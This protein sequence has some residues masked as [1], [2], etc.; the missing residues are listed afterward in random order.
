MWYLEVTTRKELGRKQM[1]ANKT[2]FCFVN[3]KNI[4]WVLKKQN[5]TKKSVEEY[6]SLRKNIASAFCQ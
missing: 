4:P 6:Y 5:G 1:E 2:N 3:T